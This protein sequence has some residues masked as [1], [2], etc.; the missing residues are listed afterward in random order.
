MDLLGSK[1][2]K[3]IVAEA[4]ILKRALAFAIDILFVEFVVLFPFSSALDE[5]VPEESSVYEAFSILSSGSYDSLLSLVGLFTA[6]PTIAYFAILEK[7]IGQT[8][9]KRLLKLHVV[10]QTKEL[11]YWQALVRSIFLIPVFPFV[12]LWIIDPIVMFFS[13]ERQR[14]SEILSRTKVVER[15]D[16]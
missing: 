4:S 3:A 5:I 14:L 16:I 10:S 7:K 15:Y 6:I 9:G 11:K 12:L 13:K 2:G 1:T 8:I